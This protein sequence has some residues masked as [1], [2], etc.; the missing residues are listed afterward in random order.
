MVIKIEEPKKEGYSGTLKMSKLLPFEY[1]VIEKKFEEPMTGTSPYGEWNM[2]K[3]DL[4]E[5][6]TVDEKTGEKISKSFDEPEEVS[7]FPSAGL[8]KQLKDKPINTKMKITQEKKEG[9]TY[10]LYNVEML[11]AVDSKASSSSKTPSLSASEKVAALKK[12]GVRYDDIV[13]LVTKEYD[14]ISE[15]MVKTIYEGVE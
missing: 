13:A 8:H 11:D 6:T 14:D 7:F 2:Y 1:A 9:D 3:V 15:V 5:F 12:D 4:Y 10:A